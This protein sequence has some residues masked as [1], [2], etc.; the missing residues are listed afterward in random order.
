MIGA[1]QPGRC[2]TTTCA[3][4]KISRQR[5]Q[6]VGFLDDS[7][8]KVGRRLHGIPVLGTL[9]DATLVLK[10]QDV[11]SVPLAVSGN[12]DYENMGPGHGCGDFA[13]VRIWNDGD[14]KP[15]GKKRFYVWV[16]NQ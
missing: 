7:Q 4:S 11:A 3:S 5:C 13:Y 14:A 9:S 8:D 1:F 2:A 6:V 10:E 16:K 12:C 15:V